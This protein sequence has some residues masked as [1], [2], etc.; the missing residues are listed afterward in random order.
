MAE[1]RGNDD[2]PTAQS[3]K[4]DPSLLTAQIARVGGQVF[5]NEERTTVQ[6][7]GDDDNTANHDDV[8][9]LDT[10]ASNHMTSDVASFPS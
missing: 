10:G 4:E 1:E 6:L 9:Y 8:R 3:D 5:L 7:G 2:E